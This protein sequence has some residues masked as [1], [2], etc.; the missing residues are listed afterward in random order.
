MFWFRVLQGDHLHPVEG[1]G[2]VE[3]LAVSQSRQQAIC[4]KLDVLGHQVLCLFLSREL[5]NGL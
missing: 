1:V 3:D 5:G 2:R 4:H